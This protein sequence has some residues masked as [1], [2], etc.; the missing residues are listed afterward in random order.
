[1]QLTEG[2]RTG[3]LAMKVGMLPLWDQWGERHATT[4]LHLDTCQVVQ[5]KTND[6]EGYTALQLGVG[7]AK[8]SRVNI[9]TAGQYKKAGLEPNRK[10]ME[11]RVTPD[12]ILPVGTKIQAMHFIPGQ[13]SRVVILLTPFDASGC[14]HSFNFSNPF[15]MCILLL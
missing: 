10:L 8:L 14:N 2:R 13:V 11:F 15:K 3:A 5:V 4:V 1:M 6:T 12:S 7:Q 9:T